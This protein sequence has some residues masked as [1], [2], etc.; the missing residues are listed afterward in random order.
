[1]NAPS[2]GVGGAG[3]SGADRSVDRP[4]R[5]GVIGSGDAEG[6]VLVAARAVGRALARA[7]ALLVCGGLGGVMAAAAE[8]A[9]E[10]GGPVLGLLPGEDPTE[11]APGVSIPVATGLG[12]AR[13]TLLVRASEAVIAVAGEWGTMS[14]AAF[15]MKLDVPLVG[16]MD[17]LPEEFPIERFRDPAAA[18][19]RAFELA[20]GRRRKGGQP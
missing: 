14:E 3:S 4:L 19:A 9:S 1:M 6:E 12:E 20:Q 17:S 8:G 16:V 2:V 11:A 7:E 15:C 13:N 5:V 18:V 10:E